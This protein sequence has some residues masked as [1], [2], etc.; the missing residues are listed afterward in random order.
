MLLHKGHTLT[1]QT[2]KPRQWRGKQLHQ[3]LLHMLLLK[4]QA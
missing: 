2:C 3:Q 4:E 1:C